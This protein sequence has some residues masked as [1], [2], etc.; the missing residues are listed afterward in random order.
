M[1]KKMKGLAKVQLS[2]V[3]TILTIAGIVGAYFLYPRSKTQL[4]VSTT[5]SL[6][7]TGFL[8]LLKQKFEQTNPG[9]NVSF[10]S[11]GTGQAIQTAKL[12]Q[13]DMIL[14]HDPPSELTF[15]IDGYGVNRKIIAYNF[16][17]IVGPSD[18][19]AGIKSLPP[20][21]AFK[22]IAAAGDDGSALWISRGDN[23]GTHSKE[24]RLWIAA[25]FN[26]SQIRDNPWYLEAG[27]GM[28]A[29]LQLAN[30]KN[31]YTLSDIASYLTNFKKG[32]IQLVKLVEGGKDLLNVYSAIPCNPQKITSAKFNAAMTFTKYL[33]SVDGQE[34]FKDFGVQ[35]FGEAIFKPWITVS[36]SGA[37]PD[38]KQMVEQ[39]A[40][41]QGS[42]CPTQ[43]RYNAGDLFG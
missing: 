17:I 5:T 36:K 6:Y 11:Q 35:D 22:R 16:F 10:I 42:E 41:F 29:T 23:S 3:I 8:D 27:T 40:Y 7:E 38:I 1:K 32:N 43:F 2:L 12:G 20:L 30:Q 21:D 24:K 33:V 26:T 13:A 4:I 9:Y 25:E 34:L 19:P 37:P 14:V 39:Y 18:D 31:A 15:L 28:T